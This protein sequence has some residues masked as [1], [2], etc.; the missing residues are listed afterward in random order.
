MASGG[1][2]TF[3]MWRFAVRP[4]IH[5]AGQF[6][7]RAN[8]LFD[9]IDHELNPNGGGSLVDLVSNIQPNHEAA[10]THW[11]SIETN[12]ANHQTV[13]LARLGAIDERLGN[14]D[15]RMQA[16][17]DQIRAAVSTIQEGQ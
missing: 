3:M 17:E 12:L 5:G 4:A 16:L 9:K 1:G 11:K 2:A 7:K 10:E 14:G 13:V 6:V 15:E 8:A